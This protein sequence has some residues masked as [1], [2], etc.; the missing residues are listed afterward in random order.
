VLRVAALQARLTHGHPAAI[1]AAQAVAVL[2]HDALSGREP[3]ID[4]PAGIDDE[5]FITTWRAMHHD[6]IIGGRLPSQ[7]RNIA[8]SGWATVAGAHAI[9][10]VFASE[11]GRAIAAAVG[12]GGDTDTVGSIAGAIVGARHGLRALPVRWV[13]GLRD[14]ELVDA[15][16]ESCARMENPC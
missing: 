2:V 7:L 8:M 6:V 11:P 14:R 1:A 15:A 12:S 9:T 16:I 5:M 3:S 4:P 10:F 13:E